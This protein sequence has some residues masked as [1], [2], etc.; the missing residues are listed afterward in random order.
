MALLGAES[1]QVCAASRLQFLFLRC[2]L[3][4]SPVTTPHFSGGIAAA[5]APGSRSGCSSFLNKKCI[6]GTALEGLFG[7]PKGTMQ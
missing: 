5:A 4:I 1:S 2:K 3:S 7:G 6:L